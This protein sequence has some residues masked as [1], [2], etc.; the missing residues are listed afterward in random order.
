MADR[1]SKFKELQTRTGTIA[2]E[3]IHRIKKLQKVA[4]LLQQNLDGYDWVGFYLVDAG[5]NRELVLGPFAGEPTEHTRIPF[6]RGICGQAAEK[7][8]TVVVDDVSAEANYLACSPKV[9][10]EIVLP[11]FKGDHL[12]GE[13]DIDSHRS[14]AFKEEDKAFLKN[15]C[16][17]IA[18]FF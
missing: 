1:E 13:L 10:S 8:D 17:I 18:E 9:K 16:S 15:I 3:S 11:I 7:L 6:G 14:A 2:G 12:V 4:N 5:K